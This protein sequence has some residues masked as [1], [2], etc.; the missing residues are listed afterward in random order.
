M[1]KASGEPTPSAFLGLLLQASPHFL[2]RA[3]LPPLCSSLLSLPS[4]RCY[5][6]LCPDPTPNSLFFPS[7][8]SIPSASPSPHSV[9][10]SPLCPPVSFPQ[11]RPSQQKSGT[12][13]SRGT[14]EFCIWVQRLRPMCA[15]GR[16]RNQRTAK[17]PSTLPREI[18]FPLTALLEGPSALRQLWAWPVSLIPPPSPFSF[19]STSL[20]PVELL[21]GSEQS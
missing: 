8:F 15:G 17:G 11:A 16:G 9:L 1:G 3:Q 6:S 18:T 5:S 12:R 7:I 4:L 21:L 19:S 14:Q 13:V 20:A 2:S 10:M